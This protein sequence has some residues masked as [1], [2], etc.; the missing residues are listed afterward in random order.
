V[1]TIQQSLINL[2][3]GRTGPKQQEQRRDDGQQEEPLLA[4]CGWEGGLRWR[5]CWGG[6]CIRLE[7]GVRKPKGVVG[8]CITSA[9]NK[10][11]L[12]NLGC[13]HEVG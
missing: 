5:L 11:L 12:E 10:R 4:R 6:R 7:L 3:L 2:G 8:N 9:E 1:A 13:F